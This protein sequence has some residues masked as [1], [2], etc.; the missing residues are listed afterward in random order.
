MQS[1]P[2]FNQVYK[3]TNLKIHK[4]E[5]YIKWYHGVTNRLNPE[6]GKFYITNDSFFNK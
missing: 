5:E 1:E 3:S 4:I 2:G 6:C